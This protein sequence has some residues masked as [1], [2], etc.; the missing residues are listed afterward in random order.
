MRGSLSTGRDLLAGEGRSA[1][2]RPPTRCRRTAST[3]SN[4]RS[5]RRSRE[6]C[7]SSVRVRIVRRPVPDVAEQLGPREDA[8]SGRRRAARAARTPCARASATPRCRDAA[9]S[10][11]AARRSRSPLARRAAHGADPLDELLVVERRGRSRRSRAE[12]E[13]AVAGRRRRPSTITGAS[14]RHRSSSPVARDHDVGVLRARDLEAV[15]RSCCSRPSS[16]VPPPGHRRR[17]APT[18]P[19]AG[20]LP[21]CPLSRTVTVHPQP[22]G[23]SWPLSLPFAPRHVREPGR[24]AEDRDAAHRMQ[25]RDPR[26]LRQRRRVLDDLG[27]QGEHERPHDQPLVP[28]DE[29]A[30][31]DE[32]RDE[33]DDLA[34]RRGGGR[35]SSGRRASPL[36]WIPNTPRPARKICTTH[37]IAIS[38]ISTR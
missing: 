20:R 24:D 18:V 12:R 10:S 2:S 33:P 32:D 25:S 11:T 1:G 22:S 36:P 21:S 37:A 15:S 35:G 5:L 27:E 3:G 13:H 8:A 16:P 9:D 6:A 30:D 29:R 23:R 38:A 4:A 26:M 7:A 14:S 19:A 17:H 34:E 31:E 28:H